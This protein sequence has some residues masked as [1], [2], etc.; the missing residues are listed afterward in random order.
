MS[1]RFHLSPSARLAQIHRWGHG[2]L[3]LL[4]LAVLPLLFALVICLLLLFS[5][6]YSRLQAHLAPKLLR[7]EPANYLVY[8]AK[9]CYIAQNSYLRPNLC[10]LHI[11]WEAELEQAP[12]FWFRS[13]NPPSTQVRDLAWH[14]SDSFWQLKG[15]LYPWLAYRHYYLVLLPD[16]FVSEAEY[17]R[18]YGFLRVQLH[19]GH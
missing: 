15:Y 14:Y 3:A 6:R 4:S 2:L 1:V 18:L 7:I 12:W 5:Y 11:F 13:K 8:Q 17:Q 16:M 10:V 9:Y 19:P